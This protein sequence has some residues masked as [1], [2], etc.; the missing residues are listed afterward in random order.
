ME[1]VAV[2]EET[3]VVDAFSAFVDLLGWELVK[4]DEDCTLHAFLSFVPRDLNP[5]FRF[6]HLLHALAL[7]HSRLSLERS[8]HS[9]PWVSAVLDPDLHGLIDSCVGHHHG[10]GGTRLATAAR[11]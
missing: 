4:V 7:S 11:G 5:M 3:Q 6:V 10:D 1:V 2:E 8:A 9:S